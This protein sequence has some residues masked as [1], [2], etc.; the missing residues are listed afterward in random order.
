MHLE[1][2]VGAVA[3]K[4]RAA[5][6]EVS[7]P[8]DVLLGCRSGC[9]VQV[10]RGHACLLFASLVSRNTESSFDYSGRYC[11][12]LLLL[13]CGNDIKATET[14][15]CSARKGWVCPVVDC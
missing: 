11:S 3:K 15:S 10:D 5:R 1:V 9:M 7:E 6:P 13:L 8:G 2:V 12:H 4:L 14:V